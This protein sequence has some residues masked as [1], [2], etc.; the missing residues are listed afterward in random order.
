MMNI[1]AQLWRR[2]LSPLRRE[3]YEREME[4]ETLPSLDADR[5]ELVVRMAAEEVS[6]SNYRR[7]D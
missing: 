7:L 2:L 6:H 5:A 1:L 4:E 3:R